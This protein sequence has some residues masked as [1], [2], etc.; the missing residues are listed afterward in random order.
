MPRT[1]RSITGGGV[2]HVI[3]RGN[4]R[5]TV[6]YRSADYVAFVRLLGDACERVALDIFAACIMPNH[7]HLVV[8]PSQPRDLSRW[9]HWLLTTH[10]HRFHLQH[11]SVGRV[12]SGRYKAFP[13]AQD[14]HLLTVMRYVERNAVR[15]GLVSRSRDWKWGSAAWRHGTGFPASLL[16]EVPVRLPAD[17][18]RFVDEPQT[19]AEVEALRACVNRQRPY[20][21]DHWRA[22]APE[23]ESYRGAGRRPGRPQKG[24]G[25]NDQK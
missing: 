6:F 23:C 5:S 24:V 2:Y 22:T 15:A 16:A 25:R 19:A 21:A 13:I 1:A 18:G 14:V 3:S 7:F 17:W 4:N 8:R 11:G 20:G 10:S 12:W 9:A